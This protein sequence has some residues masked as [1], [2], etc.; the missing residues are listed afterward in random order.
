MGFR[1]SGGIE[2]LI[3]D[4]FLSEF[5]D[6]QSIAEK[7]IELYHNPAKR[8]TIGMQNKNLCEKFQIQ[9]QQKNIT[10]LIAEICKQNQKKK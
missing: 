1:K 5:G 7:S 8:E 4:E 9:N 3:G 6:T 10:A 2:E